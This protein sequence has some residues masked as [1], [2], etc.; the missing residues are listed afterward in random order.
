M[1]VRFPQRAY[2]ATCTPRFRPPTYVNLARIRLSSPTPHMY[3]YSLWMRYLAESCGSRHPRHETAMR[4]LG[5]VSQPTLQRFLVHSHCFLINSTCYYTNK[6]DLTPR[7]A[8]R[9][10]LSICSMST[11]A[12]YQNLKALRSLAEALRAA[13][14]LQLH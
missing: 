10:T 4:Y 11:N 7:A 5:V 6:T 14:F 2:L 12:P 1:F 9:L 8:Y 13:F 3:I